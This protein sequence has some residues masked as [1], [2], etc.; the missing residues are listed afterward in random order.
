MRSIEK[1]IKM[2]SLNNVSDLFLKPKQTPTLPYC[3]LDEKNGI[4]KIFNF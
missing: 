3:I 4:Q 2:N 1:K